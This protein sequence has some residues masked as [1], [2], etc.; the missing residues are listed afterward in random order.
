MPRVRVRNGSLEVR[1]TILGIGRTRHVDASEISTIES[2]MGQSGPGPMHDLRIAR[3]EGRSI[4]AGG[5]IESKRE[6]ETV[7]ARLG[8]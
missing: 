3:K 7:D 2:V 6:A 8:R 4:F 1:S 5:G